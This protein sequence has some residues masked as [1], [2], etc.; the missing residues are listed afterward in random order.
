MVD[1]RPRAD[2]EA[3]LRVTCDPQA[4]HE[5]ITALLLQAGQE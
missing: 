5:L 2:L 3:D 4:R 1:G